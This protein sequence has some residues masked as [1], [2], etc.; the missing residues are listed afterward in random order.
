MSGDSSC[1]VDPSRR[2]H[3][4]GRSGHRPL[5]SSRKPA[6]RQQ[7]RVYRLLHAGVAEGPGDQDA[8]HQARENG[9]LR[10]F[11]TSCAMNA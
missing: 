2:R 6:Q 5:W 1:A 8:L 3:H 4:S 7:T 9:I 10:V 11:T